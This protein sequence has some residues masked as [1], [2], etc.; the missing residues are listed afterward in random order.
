M[1][2]AELR[3]GN[4]VFNSKNEIDIV[5][6]VGSDWDDNAIVDLE[7]DGHG[8]QNT[9]KT[10]PVTEDILSKCRQLNQLTIGSYHFSIYENGFHIEINTFSKRIWINGSLL[11]KDAKLHELQNVVYDLTKIELNF[12]L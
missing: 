11:T 2:S 6:R 8:V 12:K 10:I 1:R 9:I 4:F 7:H 3:T 5:L